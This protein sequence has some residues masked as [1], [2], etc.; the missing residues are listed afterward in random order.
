MTEAQES[1]LAANPQYCRCGPPRAGLSFKE[2]G[3]LYADGRFEPSMPMKAVRLEEGCMLIGVPSDLY[4]TKTR[5]VDL[6]VPDGEDRQ[7]AHASGR[8]R[9]GNDI[10]GI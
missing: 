2:C 3:T 10:S 7:A 5:C 8:T 6:D 9:V 1:F 4:L